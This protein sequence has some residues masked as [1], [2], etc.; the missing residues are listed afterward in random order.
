M[1]RMWNNQPKNSQPLT[2]I[3]PQRLTKS[4]PPSPA[5]LDVVKRVRPSRPGSFHAIHKV[6]LGDSPYDKAKQMQLMNK[7]PERAIALFWA[8]INA[9]DKVDSALKDMAIVMKQQNR[10]EEAIEAIISLRNR[11]S[12]HAQESL[13]NILLDLYKRCGR[14]EDQIKLLKHKLNLIHQGLAFN[15]KK[16][17]TAR[18][19]GKKFR[20]TLE[21]EVTRLLGNLGWAYMQQSNYVAAEAVYRKALSIE[22]D[23]NKSCN[24]GICLMHQGRVAEAKLILRTVAPASSTGPR[25]ADSHLRSYERAHEM[26]R[27]A[28][29]KEMNYDSRKENSFTEQSL[30]CSWRHTAP[31]QSEY[32]MLNSDLGD[33]EMTTFHATSGFALSQQEFLLISDKRFQSSLFDNASIEDKTEED[34]FGDE[35]ININ[36]ISSVSASSQGMAFGVPQNPQTQHGKVET[37][38]Q[39]QRLEKVCFKENAGVKHSAFLPLNSSYT[40]Q[41]SLNSAAAPFFFQNMP[42]KET[43]SLHFQPI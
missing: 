7:N 32:E 30:Q 22:P 42:I 27:E 14:L 2:A 36:T 38:R 28:E 43:G 41:S 9:G 10:A 16:T 26:L 6:P 20:V 8:A 12:V 31:N 1:E 23:N 13:D 4:E 37:L 29:A 40:E 11:C 35:N 39:R 25:G 21:H 15:G 34:G 5:K 33:W 24:L 19:Q 17:K 3:Y 18:S